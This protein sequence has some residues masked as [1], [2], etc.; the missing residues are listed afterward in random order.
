MITEEVFPIS[1]PLP[2]I[3]YRITLKNFNKA[4]IFSISTACKNSQLRHDH[5][6]SPPLSQWSG[7]PGHRSS[8]LFCVRW[9]FSK[10]FRSYPGCFV[11]FS[12]CFGLVKCTF[13][14]FCGVF[15]EIMN[16]WDSDS[17]EI[18]PRKKVAPLNGI[19]LHLL[20]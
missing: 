2:L 10:I 11:L 17:R 6:H 14:W 13:E 16:M 15:P 12:W 9:S 19:K 20:V 3:S 7:S 1:I 4:H 8:A 5:F 18:L